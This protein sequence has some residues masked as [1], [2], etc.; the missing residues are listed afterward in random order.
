MT[1]P[2]AL[3]NCRIRDDVQW[4]F[5]GFCELGHALSQTMER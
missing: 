2:E 4:L 1:L 5:W 3:E